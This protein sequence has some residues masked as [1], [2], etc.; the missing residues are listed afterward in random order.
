MFGLT[1]KRKYNIA[2]N[3]NKNLT[4]IVLENVLDNVKL[5]LNNL[6]LKE[7]LKKLKSKEFRKKELERYF[8]CTTKTGLP[9][10]NNTKLWK[11][12]DYL[13][14]K[15]SCETKK[16]FGSYSIITEPDEDGNYTIPEL[17]IIN[18]LS[19]FLYS[20]LKFSSYSAV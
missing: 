9:I 19:I 20:V 8:D 18:F 1:T 11:E 14:Q 15:E 6:D 4:K 12:Y 10:D 17:D 7:E 16:K 13:F 2:V 3:H 5:K